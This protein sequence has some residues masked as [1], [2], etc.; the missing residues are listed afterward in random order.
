MTSRADAAQIPS[1]PLSGTAGRPRN[2]RPVDRVPVGHSG[3]A[4]HFGDS[5]SSAEAAAGIDGVTGGCSWP[6]S[7]ATRCQVGW[8]TRSSTLGGGAAFRLRGGG[9][10]VGTVGAVAAN[11]GVAAA[12][13]IVGMLRSGVAVVAA[14]SGAA[15]GF[16]GAV[17]SGT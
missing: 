2:G 9:R 11:A 13:G 16:V 15:G 6:V 3:L 17:D 12:A 10:G 14:A 1:N 7:G 8:T 5:L 4:G